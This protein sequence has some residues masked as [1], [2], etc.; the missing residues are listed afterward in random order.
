[1]AKDY[2]ANPKDVKNFTQ[3][4]EVGLDQSF[5]DYSEFL[6]FINRTESLERFFGSTVNQLLSSGSTQSIDA[7]WGRLAGR[8]YNPNNE[9]FQFEPDATR[10][11]Y[12]FQPGTVS[13]V[14]GQTEQTVVTSIG[15]SVSKVLVLILITMIDF[16]VSWDMC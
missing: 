7:Y 8:N 6:P 2:S 3:G 15:S 4:A 12:Q 10:L 1:M 5:Q 16:S 14:E 11:N 13:R 9:L